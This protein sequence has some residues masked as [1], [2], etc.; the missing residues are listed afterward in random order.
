M[1]N[2][3]VIKNRLNEYKKQLLFIK[4][5][6]SNKDVLKKYINESKD[7]PTQHQ[8][9]IAK[10]TLKMNDVGAN[11]MG[12]MSKSEARACLKKNGYSDEQI[13]KLEENKQSLKEYLNFQ[14]DSLIPQ[15]ETGDKII[16][17]E[18]SRMPQPK[19]K[20]LMD[21]MR[22]LSIDAIKELS[23]NANSPEYEF[24]KTV[25]DKCDKLLKQKEETVDVDNSIQESK[26]S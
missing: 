1:T 22:L 18:I 10:K 12:G 7:V 9:S 4:E 24:F 26:K 19:F 3:K 20:D 23:N 5:N 11:I 25:L 21:K 8:I 2:K 6:I 17:R 14:E 15:H 13:K 16:D